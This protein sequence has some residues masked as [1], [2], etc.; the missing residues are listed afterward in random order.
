MCRKSGRFWNPYGKFGGAW[1][2]TRSQ[3]PC[4][5]VR[6]N[7]VWTINFDV[8]EKEQVDRYPLEENP[9]FLPESM[10][11]YVLMKMDHDREVLDDLP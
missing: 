11:E 1:L 6:Q 2:H 3:H 10:V 4:S 8:C 9:S 5:S 7:R